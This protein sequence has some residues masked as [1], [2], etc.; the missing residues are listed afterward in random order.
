VD[1]VADKDFVPQNYK[2]RGVILYGNSETNAAWKVLL[3]DCPV[4][5]SKGKIA[6]G[7]KQL[8][9]DLAAYFIWPRADS[10]VASVAVISGTGKK[11]FQAA[12]AN[13]YFSG[14]SGF[15]DLMIFSSG[16]LKNGVKEVKMAGFFGNDW[17]VEK[18]EFVSND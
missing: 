2:D 14:G 6:V 17:S 16:M 10:D 8:T 3:K 18:G 15:P 7:D 4:N 12:N 1:I 11:G 5:V 13:Q 9:G